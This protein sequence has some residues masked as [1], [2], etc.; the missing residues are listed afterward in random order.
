MNSMAST[1][2]SPFAQFFIIT[3]ESSPGHCDTQ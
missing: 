2:C 1:Y 3:K